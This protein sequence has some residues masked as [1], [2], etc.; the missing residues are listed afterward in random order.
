[1]ANGLLISERR[2]T[3]VGSERFAQVPR[4]LLITIDAAAVSAPLGPGL[5][6]GRA[7]NLSAY[8]A[9]HLELSMRRGLPLTTLDATSR[10][11]ATH[12]GVALT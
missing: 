2:L 1:M 11:A 12:V 6:L 8:D 7:H 4:S 10:E 5:A 9:A 3:Q